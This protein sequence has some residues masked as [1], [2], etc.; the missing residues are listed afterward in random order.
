M[1]RIWVT[2]PTGLK[3]RHVGILD[4]EEFYKWLFRWLE[5]EGYISESSY[6]KAYNEQTTAGGKQ[7]FIQWHGEKQKTKDFRY[8]IDVKWI[9]VGVNS[10]EIQRE[11]KKVK[12]FKGDFDIRVMAYLEKTI[13]GGGFLRRIYDMFIIRRRV[14]EHRS[15]LYDKVTTLQNEIVQFFNQYVA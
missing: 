10:I 6:E 8:V 5:F 15:N 2:P 7:I 13:G 3:I 1:E 14:D 9:L 4:L 12:L 11:D